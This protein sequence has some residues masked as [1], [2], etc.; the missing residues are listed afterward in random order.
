MI[1]VKKRETGEIY[2]FDLYEKQ[3]YRYLWV[4]SWLLPH[5]FYKVSNQVTLL[6]YGDKELTR[7]T[8]FILMAFLSSLAIPQL[9]CSVFL[10][11]ANHP[12]SWLGFYLII[13]NWIPY[14]YTLLNGCISEEQ[15]QTEDQ[16]KVSFVSV[17]GSWTPEGGIYKIIYL[18]VFIYFVVNAS[19]TP[20]GIVFA[21]MT[22]FIMLSTVSFNFVEESYCESS[23]G[24]IYEIVNK[25][26]MERE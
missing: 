12:I 11:D 2:T 26:E 14:L 24:E 9:L 5:R 4:F 23:T 22:P 8:I 3:W 25:K 19:K 1:F 13:S 21:V 15:K 7:N 17:R 18:F 10:N 20:D 6:E 16:E